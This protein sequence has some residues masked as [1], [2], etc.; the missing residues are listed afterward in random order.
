MPFV[1]MRAGDMIRA[2]ALYPDVTRAANEGDQA[3]T[4]VLLDVLVESGGAIAVSPRLAREAA[5]RSG[6][7]V[8]WLGPGELRCAPRRLFWVVVEFDTGQRAAAG[9][10]AWTAEQAR[11]MAQSWSLEDWTDA[12]EEDLSDVRDFRVA[13][14]NPQ[15]SEIDAR[16]R[17]TWE[18]CRGIAFV[19]NDPSPRATLRRAFARG[20]VE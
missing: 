9:F 14:V 18:D 8:F 10:E 20:Q 6:S 5:A 2:R 17:T 13:R 19:S 4:A 1:V 15:T 3:A 11:S 16:H 7:D 12:E